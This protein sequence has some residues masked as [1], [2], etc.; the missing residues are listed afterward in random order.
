MEENAFSVSLT[1]QDG[2]A[3]LVDLHQEGVPL[4]RVDEPPPLGAGDGPNAARLLAA[5]VGNCM[6]ASLKFC[7]DRARIEVREMRTEVEGHYER[8]A[9]GRLRIGGLRVRIEPTVDEEQAQRMA[10]CMGI[11]EDFC[12]VGQSV[13]QG[14][15]VEVEVV[16]S[17][18]SGAATGI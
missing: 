1:L 14:I 9:E 13:K 17:G 8:N 3:F 7:L 16:P 4:L 18:V 11:F 5:A 12:T 2:Y 6:S 15:E 10:R